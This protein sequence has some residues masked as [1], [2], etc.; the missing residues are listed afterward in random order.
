MCALARWLKLRHRARAHSVTVASHSDAL[1]GTSAPLSA[2]VLCM[3][4]YQPLESHRLRIGARQRSGGAGGH[5]HD[6]A[7]PRRPRDLLRHG[8]HRRIPSAQP[9]FAGVDNT[10]N[11]PFN[12]WLINRGSVT[13]PLR[14]RQHNASAQ[15]I[16]EHLQSL[17]RVRFVAYPGLE[18]HPH[19]A[20][21]ASQ[22][23]P[24]GRRFRRGTRVR[25]EHRPWRTQPFRQQTQ[26][27]HVGGVARP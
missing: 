14:M 7:E 9:D 18:S 1:S 2:T 12:A 20:F 11:S 6:R 5:V 27:H 4:G 26:R 10:F 21:A 24:P 25:T 3:R 19:H 17:P 22:L 8:L 23:G 15:A 16:A 13:L